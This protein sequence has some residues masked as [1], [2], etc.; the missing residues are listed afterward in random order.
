MQDLRLLSRL[1]ASRSWFGAVHLRQ[2]DKE[3]SQPRQRESDIH[4]APLLNS[5]GKQS[6]FGI[7]SNVRADSVHYLLVLAISAPCNFWVEHSRPK[8]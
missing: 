1:S 6:L 4:G 8:C 2:K 7:I 5:A 3:L